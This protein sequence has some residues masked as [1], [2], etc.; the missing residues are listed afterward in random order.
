MVDSS[1]AQGAA[2]NA[3]AQPSRNFPDA[4]RVAGRMRAAFAQ[5]SRECASQLK[6]ANLVLGGQ[7]VRLRTVGFKVHDRIKRPLS[8]PCGRIGTRGNRLEF[9][10]GDSRSNCY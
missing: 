3:P 8:W 7:P 9:D 5:A 2:G 1:E 4:D 10:G 6:E